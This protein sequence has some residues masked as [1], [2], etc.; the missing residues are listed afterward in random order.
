M[1]NRVLMTAEAD[2]GLS[3]GFGSAIATTRNASIGAAIAHAAA[4]TAKALNCAAIVCN[5]TSGT[6]A[7]RVARTRPTCPILC[8][9]DNVQTTRRMSL[10]WGT[11]AVMS[12]KLKDWRDIVVTAEKLS[13]QAGM[14]QKGD[15]IAVTAGMPLNQS[16]TTN[17]LRV[18]EIE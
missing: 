6:T 11:K 16:G 4:E 1:M 18:V 3:K 17:I 2:E 14:V 9:S 15:T 7:R 8:L 10:V 5:T 12:H 13:K